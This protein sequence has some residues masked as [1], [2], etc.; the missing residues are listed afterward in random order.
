[1]VAGLDRA[2]AQRDNSTMQEQRF[3]HMVEEFRSRMREAI[4]HPAAGDGFRA[5]EARDL[6]INLDHLL[7]QCANIARE[8]ML[9][10]MSKIAEAAA[11]LA[12]SPLVIYPDPKKGASS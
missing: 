7:M 6:E 1:M 8:P 2:A 3:L 12:P 10:H 5:R 11:V 4:L 9:R